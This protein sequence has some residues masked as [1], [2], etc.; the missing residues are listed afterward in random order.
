L[1]EKYAQDSLDSVLDLEE[2]TQFSQKKAE[3]IKFKMETES[4]LKTIPELQTQEEPNGLTEG[5]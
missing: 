5:K 3:I 4:L 1:D 2:I